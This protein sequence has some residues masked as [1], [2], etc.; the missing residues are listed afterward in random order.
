MPF[1]NQRHLLPRPRPSN[2]DG[3]RLDG[4]SGEPKARK[5]RRPYVS[6]ACDSC[7]ERKNA[8]DGRP[9]CSQ[10]LRRGIKCEY[11]IISDS[12]WKK[13][14]VGTQLVDKEEADSNAEAAD[15]LSMLKS[16]SDGE[17]L[18]A[19][20][21]LRTGSDPA[22][23]SSAL[24]NG[25]VALS[26]TSPGRADL[27]PEQLPLEF[28]L[29]MKYP[30]AYPIGSLIHP[31]SMDSDFLGGFHPNF[32]N[33]AAAT[34]ENRT[35][36][37]PSP[38][39]A[40]S[41]TG[42]SP[43]SKLFNSRLLSVDISKWTNVPI[44]NEFSIKVLSLYFEVEHPL[45]PL[46]DVEF[47]L[48]GL[49][50]NNQFCS[51]LLVNALFAWASLKYATVDPDA[52]SMGYTFYEEAKKLW[53]MSVTAFACGAGLD[54]ERYLC[55]M[56]DMAEILEL[57]GTDLI[58]PQDPVIGN[59]SSWQL[60]TAQMAWSIFNCLM[61]FSTQ[62]RKR[63]IEHPPRFPIPGF[64]LLPGPHDPVTR[65]DKRRFY[66]A[67]LLRENC[68]LS[69]IVHDMLR[70]MYGPFADP[71][72]NVVSLAFA[73]QT[74]RRL[75]VWADALPLELARGDDC[76]HHTLVLHIYYHLAV[77]DLMRP[78]TRHDDSATMLL[79]PFTSDKAIPRAV[80]AASVN[81]LK[82]IVLY[83]RRTYPEPLFSLFWHS[84]LLYLANEALQEM[85]VPHRNPEWRF[86]FHLCLTCYQTLYSGYRLV[87]EIVQ[88]LLSMA[89]KKGVMKAREAV[90]IMEG[91]EMRGK[92]R[93]VPDQKMVS[94]VVDLDLAVTD[95]S[96]AY[97]ETLAQRFRQI[98]IHGSEQIGKGD[99]QTKEQ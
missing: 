85:D 59:D 5:R 6:K 55:E 13:V 67:N 33:P 12:A 42:L 99:G 91:L 24:R 2:A 32:T 54:H 89:L 78:L 8:C 61:F 92:H 64:S 38:F 71:Q 75:L 31:P 15:L 83:Y 72:F 51:C 50:G 22:E 58:D 87:G 62:L 21:R 96:E 88:S 46:F 70:V 23:L 56:S 65:E 76:A 73:E 49:L 53:Y 44:S 1:D 40:S 30:I 29:M 39:G 11:R 16:V 57:F 66:R 95:P 34:Y 17:A 35:Q 7:R 80:H 52:A 98:Q 82:K 3:N 79:R 4:E 37:Y 18:E 93:R 47:F 9:T 60:A 68:K 69:L 63:M 10:C 41:T 26:R 97:V 90:A 36:P 20:Q 14:P 86:Y 45:M 27:P 43:P 28:E 84:A 94:L 74:C 81:Q 77:L 48:E 25:G 19:L